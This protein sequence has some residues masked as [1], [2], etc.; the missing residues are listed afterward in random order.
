M[1]EE[2][3]KA[4]REGFSDGYA[5]AKKDFVRATAPVATVD[6]NYWNTATK[7]LGVT[8]KAANPYSMTA[9][10]LSDEC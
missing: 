8:T 5:L 4:Y 6:T 2:W 7:P 10:M 3:K 1:N 9:T